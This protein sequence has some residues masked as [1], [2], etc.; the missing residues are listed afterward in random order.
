M[1]AK[2]KNK[3]I[4]ACESKHECYKQ[5]EL[6]PVQRTG[7]SLVTSVEYFTA[8]VS[9]SFNCRLQITPWH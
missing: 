6:K 3:L 1:K 7:L 5:E 8:Y 2:A 9:Q 4:N